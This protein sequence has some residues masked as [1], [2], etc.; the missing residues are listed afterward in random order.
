MDPWTTEID[1]M[2]SEW[3]EEARR[4]RRRSHRP[5][6]RPAP[7]RPP[8]PRYP[9]SRRPTTRVPS[10]R[11]FPLP[12]GGGR[13]P[14][15][16]NI[17]TG[18][19]GSRE[20]GGGASGSGPVGEPYSAAAEPPQG[21]EFMRWVQSTLNLVSGLNLPVD[22]LPGPATRSAI[23]S[24]QQRSGLPSD[25][26]VGPDTR[27]ALV[28]AR[29]QKSGAGGAAGSATAADAPPQEE[30]SYTSR[31]YIRWVQSSLNRIMGAN[32]A[33]DGISGPATRRAV[34]AFQRSRGL[35]ADG[36]PGPRTA[37][38]LQAAGAPAPPGGGS[39]APPAPSPAPYLPTPS[40]SGL[41]GRIVQVALQELQR[42]G[43]GKG[44][45]SDPAFRPVV[46]TYWRTGVGYLP[47]EPNWW[48]SVPWS[49]AFISYV[50]RQAGAG[51]TF[52]YSGGHS[53]YT[54]AARNNRLA[55]NSNP[56]K[57][58]RLSEVAPQPGDLVC[59]ARAG[60][61]ATYDNLREGM[62]THCDV[63]VA[64]QTG[65]LLTVGGNVSD[66]VKTTPVTIDNNG[67]VT[68]SGYF[69]VI[70]SGV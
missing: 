13:P 44:K 66:S 30:I 29:Q 37:A 25:G 35:A 55:N 33:V 31:D 15:T 58:Y 9:A 6:R 48:S 12:V 70:K 23:R 43:D 32:L 38:A 69:A 52:R 56:F 1:A 8:R 34:I 27:R 67:R 64:V 28:K 24:F 20:P 59:K 45:E 7:P 10:K 5:V 18:R 50:M 47:N 16:I 11:I 61:G 17:D 21:S 51:S 53:Y 46:E 3:E 49:A 36:I 4:R 68:Q 41:R 39:V 19:D 2:N 26:I 40:L 60:S 62:S 57:A 65:R 42:W 54:V 14:V 22:G 63:V